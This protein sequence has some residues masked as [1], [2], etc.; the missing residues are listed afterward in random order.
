[1]AKNKPAKKDNKEKKGKKDKG[2]GKRMKKEAMIQAIISVFQSSPKEPFNY[3]QI[4][5]IIG[6]ENQVQK[7]QVVDILYDLSEDIITEIDRGRYRL[8]GLGTLAVGTF[9]RRSNGKNSFIPEDGGTPVFIAERNSGH[10][11]DGDKVKVQLFAKR[12]G[13]EPEGEVVEILE[14]KERTFVGKLQVAKGFAFLI[15]ENKTLANDIFIPKDKLKGGK[16]GDKAIVRIVEWPDEAKNPLGEVIDILGIAGQNTAEMHAILAEFGLP[17]KYPSSVEKAADKI[18]EAISP[19]EIENREDF[20]GITTFTIDPKDAKDFDDALS[21]RR[22]DN[23]NWEVGVHIADVTHYVKTDGVIDKEAQSRAT[24]VYLVDRTIPMLPERLCNQICSLR[25]DEEKLCFSAVFELNSDAVVQN[26]RICRTIIKSDR[27]F[28]YEEAQEVIETGEGDY[29]EEILALNDLAK[30]LRERRF[31]SG[32]INFDRYEVKFEIDEQGKPVRV[33][34]KISKDANKLIEEFMLLANRTVA[35]FVGRPPKGKTK[36]TFVYRIH[37]LPDPDKMENFASFIRRFGYKLKTDGTKTDVS[38]GINSLLDNVQGK[39]E[40]NLIETVAIRAM[41]KARYSTENIGHYGLA[42]EYYTHF[43]SPIRRYPD[44]MVHRLLERYLAGGRSV[45]QKKYEDLCD[46]CSNMEQ[47]AANAERA[48]IKYKQVEFMQDKLGMV[49]DGVISGVTE[50]GL[51]VELNENKCEGLVP[52][53]DLDDDYY[54]FDE[55]NYCLL[56]R[57]KKRQYRLGDPIT[58]KVAQA[59]LERKQLDFQLAE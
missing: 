58:I 37:E 45:I 3:K 13:A 43:T 47:V 42:F 18:P 10:A 30:K 49:F 2:S 28:T 52:I 1:M 16:N 24:S 7:L 36:K 56:G 59:N 31:K 21:A 34:F 41:Q 26:S 23:G 25:P 5:K 50:W 22:L 12:K 17:Y 53:R 57:R 54:E 15:T 27:R 6:V 19:E 46:H 14:S 8:N 29:K 20:R 51:Y 55:K 11:M 40:E 32:A 44:M 4:S 38:K 35:E 48:S 39:P 33:Y 9:A